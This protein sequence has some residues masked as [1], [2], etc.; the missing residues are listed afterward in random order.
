MLVKETETTVSAK[1]DE[2]KNGLSEREDSSFDSTQSAEA[3]RHVI[4][5][6]LII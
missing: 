4:T 6:H 5:Y 1:V 2:T 3:N